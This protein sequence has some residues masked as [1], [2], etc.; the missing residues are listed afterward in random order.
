M[1]PFLVTVH[2]ATPAYARET[3]S[4]IRD[5]GPLIGRRLSVGVVPDWHGR[6]PLAEY[7]EYCHL[8]SEAAEEL[9]LHGYSHQRRNGRGPATWLTGGADEMN[10]FDGEETRGI[11]DR[12][13][14]VF[15]DAFGKPSGGFLAPAWQRGQVRANIGNGSG[16]AYVLG[17]FSLE[18]AAGRRVRLATST[19]DCGRWNWLGHVGHG[20][21]RVLQS[22]EGRVPSL[23]IH[24]R[25]LDRGFW[26]QI[27]RLVRQLLDTGYEPVT[28]AGLLEARRAEAAV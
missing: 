26:P 11:I 23:A 21:G 1:Q 4:M 8:L 24:P 2:D 20:I 15:T 10:D 16:L 5:L 9:L 12:G 7:P 3:A 6:W 22:L 25:D 17:F 14:R 13:Q 27:L 28:P 18:S 19:W